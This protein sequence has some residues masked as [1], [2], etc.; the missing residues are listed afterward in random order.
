MSPIHASPPAADAGRARRSRALLG[1]SLDL[2]LD[3]GG[4]STPRPRAQR[5]DGGLPVDDRQ[6]FWRRMADYLDLLVPAHGTATRQG[7]GRKPA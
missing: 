3:H 4:L 2:Y 6:A 7:S 1:P 5:R